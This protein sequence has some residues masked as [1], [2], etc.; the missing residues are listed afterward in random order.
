MSRSFVLGVLMSFV[1]VSGLYAWLGGEQPRAADPEVFAQMAGGEV[2][3]LSPTQWRKQAQE[4]ANRMGR[5]VVVTKGMDGP[6]M[7]LFEPEVCE[8]WLEIDEPLEV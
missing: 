8:D 1:I 6:V 7:G 2:W 3:G 5:A 4:A